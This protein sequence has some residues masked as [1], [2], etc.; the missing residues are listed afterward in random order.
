MKKEIEEKDKELLNLEIF[1]GFSSSIT[2]LVLVFVVSFVEMPKWIAISLIIYACIILAMGVANAIKIEQIAGYYE[3]QKC[4][5][6]YVPTYL[7]VFAAP[8]IN[9]TR[10]MRCPECNEKSWQKKVISKD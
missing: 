8:H 2:F 10:Y 6:K 3:C 1:I 4:H 5:H 7:S 9:R